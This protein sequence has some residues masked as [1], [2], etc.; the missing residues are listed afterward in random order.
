MEEFPEIIYK[1]V[2]TR[3]PPG[4][5]IESMPL[6]GLLAIYRNPSLPIPLRFKA[7]AEAAKYMHPRMGIQV[8]MDEHSFAARLEKAVQRAAKIK[9]GE[10][11]KLAA[12]GP[13]RRRI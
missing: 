7:M 4:L 12:P 8:H 2:Q 1:E 6:D 3:D 9:N 10:L 11:K 5:P 13:I